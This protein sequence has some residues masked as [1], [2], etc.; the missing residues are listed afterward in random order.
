MKCNFFT[1]SS[2]FILFAKNWMMSEI[3]EKL[4]CSFIKK[5]WISPFFLASLSHAW[6]MKSES[7][8]HVIFCLTNECAVLKKL[9]YLL[10]IHLC[11]A[12]KKHYNVSFM[13]FLF[14]GNSFLKFP[15]SSKGGGLMME[16]VM[17]LDLKRKKVNWKRKLVHD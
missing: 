12:W 5:T 17:K 14:F 15:W 3:Y 8:V 7:F 4:N 16:W 10:N 6:E 1:P 2:T 13:C 11:L 9:L